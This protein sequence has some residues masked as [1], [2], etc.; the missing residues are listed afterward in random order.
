MLDYLKKIIQK[1][2]LKLDTL[3]NLHIYDELTKE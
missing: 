2:Q 3:L 1:F